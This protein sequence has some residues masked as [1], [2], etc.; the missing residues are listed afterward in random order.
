MFG[1][2]SN[3]DTTATFSQLGTYVLRFTM[4]YGL[5]VSN[6]YVTVVVTNANTKNA[7]PYRESF[8][9]Y[10]NGATL[11][12][13]NG[14]SPAPAEAARI[15]TNNYTA[16]YTHGYPIVGAHEL[17]LSLDGAITNTFENTAA[18]TNVWIDMV[19]ECRHWLDRVP[20]VIESNVQLSAYV[21]TNGHM[22]L[23]HC[24]TNG[25]ATNRWTELPDIHIG[26]NE[27]TRVT[28]EANYAR[29]ANTP[30]GYRLWVNSVAVTNPSTWYTMANTNQNYI[31]CVTLSGMAHFDD[32]VI[33]D[34]NTLLYRQILASYGSILVPINA[35]TN[36]DVVPSNYCRLIS[37]L[38]DGVS[39]GTPA[40]YAFTNVVADHTLSALFAANLATNDTPEWWLAQ[41]H[42]NWTNN[43]DL[44]AME[45]FDGDGDPAW[46]EWIAGTHPTNP[47]SVF[48]ILIAQTN[49]QPVVVSL[50]TIVAGPEYDGKNRY[51]SL[52]NTSNLTGAAWSA[53]PSFS[54]WLGSGQ[55]LCYTN[56]SDT[57]RVMF[58]RGQVRLE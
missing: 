20:P 48:E 4:V 44:H 29:G 16:T 35:N 46:K 2:S 56:L 32:L 51:Y 1:S 21:N 3:L 23:W 5:F 52:E 13:V 24:Q 15:W 27:F 49:G 30:P 14:W 40:A 17:V 22:V 26:S 12:G 18:H 25:P 10:E 36:F 45:D 54:H 11:V 53:I 58:Y 31:S 50:P 7:L 47:L 39:V 19:M 6:D 37:L 41:S 8:E 9:E 33:E 43:F 55:T 57:N 38:V 28:V 42:P 34:Y